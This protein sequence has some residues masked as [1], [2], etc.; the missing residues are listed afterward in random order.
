MFNKTLYYNQEKT[1]YKVL[2]SSEKQ[3]ELEI[4]DK[5]YLFDVKEVEGQLR[6]A[7]GDQEFYISKNG[8]LFKSS[9][10]EAE[11]SSKPVLKGQ[12]QDGE[13]GFL[14]PMPGKIFSLN[15]KEGQEVKKGDTLLILEAMKM[16]HA[17]NAP[18][19]GVVTKVFYG[20]GDQ[21]QAK[22]PLIE[23]ESSES[24]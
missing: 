13:T 3:I 6:L 14:S 19:D 9:H 21:V 23:M 12:T 16:E 24:E 1:L 11:L 17:I 18:Y 8:S 4:E 15:V 20:L 5:K 22:V 7:L 10:L 2:R